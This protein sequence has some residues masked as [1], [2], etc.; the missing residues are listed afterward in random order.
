M[1]RSHKTCVAVS[2]L[3]LLVLCGQASAFTPQQGLPGEWRVEGFADLWVETINAFNSVTPFGIDPSMASDGVVDFSA[4][5]IAMFNAP[6]AEG[7]GQADDGLYNA[8][9]SYFRLRIGDTMWDET[10]PAAIQFQVNGGLVTGASGPYTV[11][12]PEHPDLSFALP[13]SPGTWEALDER[14]DV[15]RG[16]IAGTYSL[17]DGVVIPEPASLSLFGLGVLAMMRRRRR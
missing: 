16:T 14:G 9:F 6:D 13:A 5:M 11:T 4:G 17:R 3:S 10:M 8:S 1:I 7:D 15:N 12:R 2:I